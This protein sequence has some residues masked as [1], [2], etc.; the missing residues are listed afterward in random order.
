M[1]LAL[2]DGTRTISGFGCRV[3]GSLPLPSRIYLAGPISLGFRVEGLGFRVF[4]GVEG[5]QLWLGWVLGF[6]VVF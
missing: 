6:R 3:Q 4:W 2:Q 5:C 1:L